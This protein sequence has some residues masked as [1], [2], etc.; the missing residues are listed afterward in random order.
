MVIIPYFNHLFKQN[1]FL[2]S[3]KQ[4][5]LNHSI[6]HMSS[7]AT[8]PGEAVFF[9]NISARSLEVHQLAKMRMGKILIKF[10]H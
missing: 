1:Y 10:L 6:F 7:Q 3:L 5:V 4:N 2:V 9:H 8:I